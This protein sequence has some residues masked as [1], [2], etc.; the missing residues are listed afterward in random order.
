MALAQEH[1]GHGNATEAAE[2]AVRFGYVEAGGLEPSFT[3]PA[4]AAL[5]GDGTERYGPR[6]IERL[7]APQRSCWPLALRH[8]VYDPERPDGQRRPNWPTTRRLGIERP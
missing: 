1:W 3:N 8:I 2:H 6:P 4:N 7:L 5:E